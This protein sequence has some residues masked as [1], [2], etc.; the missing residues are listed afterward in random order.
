M[1]EKVIFQR[2]AFPVDC[3]S[4]INTEKKLHIEPVLSNSSDHA[5]SYF[6]RWVR[7]NPT[8]QNWRVDESIIPRT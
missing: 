7:E 3:I 1:S 4:R 2:V 8:A 5:R 6:E